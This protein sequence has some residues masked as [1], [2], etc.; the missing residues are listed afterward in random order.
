MITDFPNNKIIRLAR[1]NCFLLHPDFAQ[2]LS[3]WLSHFSFSKLRQQT[4]QRLSKDRKQQT[5]SSIGPTL[6]LYYE[7]S[8]VSSNL[9]SKQFSFHGAHPKSFIPSNLWGTCATVLNHFEHFTTHPF[10]NSTYYWSWH[11]HHYQLA[12]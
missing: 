3:C 12:H 1:L 6:C 7:E 9:N 8:L 10:T 4:G 2:S 11:Y 5:K